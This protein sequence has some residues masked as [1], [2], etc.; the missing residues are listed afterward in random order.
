MQLLKGDI[1][2]KRIRVGAVA[3]GQ[4]TLQFF[5]HI[6]IIPTMIAFGRLGGGKNVV[7]Q[8]AGFA[9]ALIFHSNREGWAHSTNA[10]TVAGVADPSAG[11]VIFRCNNRE[12]AN[13][14]GDTGLIWTK[15]GGTYKSSK[16][17]KSGF[18]SSKY[19]DDAKARAAIYRKYREAEGGPPSRDGKE[20]KHWFCSMYVIACW[21][22]AMASDAEVEQYMRLDASYSTPMT[23]A[24]YLENHTEWTKYT[25]K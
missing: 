25:I 16:A 22:A 19:G 11:D 3:I 4:G 5:K 2:L 23:L 24:T 15:G 6:S 9:H 1:Q 14:A 10:G 18:R 21:Q 17:L 13:L 12:K 20:Q 8:N 7:I